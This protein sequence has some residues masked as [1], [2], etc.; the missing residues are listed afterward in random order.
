VDDVSYDWETFQFQ[1]T[2]GAVK[3]GTTFQSFSLII[4]FIL[5]LV[6]VEM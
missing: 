1:H 2:D 3:V 6:P 4:D 5:W